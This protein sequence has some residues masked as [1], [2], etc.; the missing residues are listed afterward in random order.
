MSLARAIFGA[1]PLYGTPP[2]A[3]PVPQTG[4]ANPVPAPGEPQHGISGFLNRVFNPTNGLG[5]FSQALFAAGGDPSQAMAYMMRSRAE[6]GRSDQEF[7]QFQRKYDYETAHP[8]PHEQADDVFTRT[9]IAAGIDPTSE[10]GKALYGQRAAVLASPAPNFISDGLGGGN[11][12]QPPPPSLPGAPVAPAA[13][14]PQTL[15][16]DFD[17]GEGGAGGNARRNFRVR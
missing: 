7:A 4:G 11:W 16:P 12:V 9:L 8:R 1:K 15:P 5:Q 2:F 3:G 17:F 6:A 13:G 10:Q 14:P